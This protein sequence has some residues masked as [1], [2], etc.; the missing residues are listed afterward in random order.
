[1]MI[2]MVHLLSAYK[3]MREQGYDQGSKEYVKEFLIEPYNW[4][5]SQMEKRLSDYDGK[6]YPVW[7]HKQRPNQMHRMYF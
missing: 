7:L 6:G 1:M 2:Y 5:V 4:M 3:H